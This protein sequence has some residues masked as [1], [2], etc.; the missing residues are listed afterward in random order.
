M[1]KNFR[2]KLN[3]W[4]RLSTTNTLIFLNVVVFVLLFVGL[5]WMRLKGLD[6]TTVLSYVALNPELFVNGYFWTILTSMFVHIDPTHLLV[7]MISLF[8]LGT[9]VEKLIGRKRFAWFYLLSGLI[10]GVLF[11][12]FAYIGAH[13]GLTNIF[14]SPEMFAV[15]ASG[16]IFALGS[17]LAVLLP[18]LKVLVFFV[19][20]MPLWL[21]MVVMMFGLWA[22]S[23]ALSLP[24][25][26]T[27]HFGGLLAGLIYG[28]YLR[29]KYARKVNMIR[30]IFV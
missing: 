14:G 25:G 24:I 9:F 28:L 29:I 13:F 21:A 3:F 15:G 16:A 5:L 20:P 6:Q 1:Y 23:V 17:M 11:V 27:A 2:K 22:V 4:S 30:K 12:G 19:I 26:N 7:N 18:R 10:A 8:F